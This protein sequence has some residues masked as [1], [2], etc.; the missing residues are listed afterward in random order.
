MLKDDTILWTN[1]LRSLTIFVILNDF[2][3]TDYDNENF[4]LHL[5]FQNIA[6]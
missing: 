6:Y 2:R 1:A 3:V 4:I 5:F